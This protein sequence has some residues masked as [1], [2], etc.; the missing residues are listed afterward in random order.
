MFVRKLHLCSFTFDFSDPTSH[1]REKEMKRETL[2]ELVE[3]VTSGS[4]RFREAVAPDLVRMFRA[5]LFRSLPPPRERPGA[6][7]SGGLAGGTDPDEEDPQLEPAWPHLQ[8]V[9]E[10]LLRYVVSPDT[11]A[12][13]ARRHV[14]ASFVLG[15]LDLFDSEDPRERDYLKTTLHRIYGKFMS[16]RPF[17]RRAI[18]D[19]FGRFVFETERHAGIAEL[20]EILGSIINGFALPLKEEHKL[21]LKRSLMPLHK[22]RSM[23]IYHQQL[24]YCVGQF[25]DKDPS[26]AVAVVRGLLRFW[27]A[28]NSHKEVLF[29]GELEEVLELAGRDELA[30][31]AAP[32]FRRVAKCLASSHFQVAERALFLWNSDRVVEAVAAHRDVVLPIVLPALEANARGH[33]NPAVHSLSLNVRRMFQQMDG[34]LFDACLRDLRAKQAAETSEQ[35]ELSKRW[36]SIERLAQERQRKEDE[37][38]TAAKQI[39]VETAQRAAGLGRGGRGMSGTIPA[40]VSSATPLPTPAAGLGGTVPPS[41]SATY[42]AD[43]GVGTRAPTAAGSRPAQGAAQGATSAARGGGGGPGPASAPASTSAPVSTSASASASAPQA[44]GSGG[45]SAGLP[46]P[47]AP[48]G[49][50]AALARG[51]PGVGFGGPAP[52]RTAARAAKKDENQTRNGLGSGSFGRP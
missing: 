38:E 43:G 50:A 21:F 32:A 24:A 27:P 52:P 41:G 30:Q 25:V 29:L 46:R 36:K 44:A 9:H 20:L 37:R 45:A 19:V 31:L 12:R 34:R 10:L 42:T 47:A 39:D 26:L 28:T 1:V 7:E 51:A 33:W 6:S 48:G 35:A 5:N 15:L 16:H 3:Y 4:G 49:G 23:P 13:A 11:D 17:I 40:S 14:D 8:I 18:A 2:L 22:P